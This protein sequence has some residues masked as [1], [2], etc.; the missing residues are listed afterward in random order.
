MR[1]RRKDRDGSDK[2]N[3]AGQQN[4][5]QISLVGVHKIG[6]VLLKKIH[7]VDSTIIPL[8]MLEVCFSLCRVYGGLFLTAEMIDCLLAGD[9]ERAAWFAG[10]LLLLNVF[11]GVAGEVV[12]RKFRGMKN[13]IWLI[14]YVWLREK[15]FSLDYETMENP[16]VAEKILYSERTSD[17]YGGLGIMLYQYCEILRSALNVLLSSAMVLSLCLKEPAQAK[18]ILGML[19]APLSSMLLFALVLTGMMICAFRVFQRFA[20]KQM[21]IFGAH[22]GVENRLM[23]LLNQIYGNVK[24]AKIIRIYGMEEMIMENTRTDQDKSKVYFEQMC[25]VERQEGDAN[26][27]VNSFFTVASYLLVAV[28]TVTG[29]ITVGAFTRYA[30]ALNQFGN[31]CF[32]M[33][34]S[35]GELRKIATYMKEFLDFLNT[36]SMHEKGSIPVE[37]REDGEYELA[38]ENVSFHYPGNEEL[39]LKDVNCRLRIRGKLAVVGRNGAG[40]TTFIKLLCRLYEPTKGRITLNGVDIR[41]YDEEEYRRLFGVV[42]QDFKLFAFPVWENITAGSERQKERIEEALRQADAKEMVEKMPQGIDTYLYKNLEDGVEVSGGEAQKLALARALYKDA[43]VVI[44]DEPTAALDP[45]AEAE[46]YAHFNKMVE[47][48][49]SI[50]ISH[51]MSSCR[52]CDDIIVFENGRIVERGSHEELFAAGGSYARMWNAQAKYYEG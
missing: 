21:E 20:K 35:N 4:E 11:F 31:A 23:Y 13:K 49:T 30:G 38:F 7:S 48:R 34:S 12:R 18:G 40:K 9:F 28:K 42:F 51:R 39:A 37:K 15:A 36:E 50:Y 52:F 14:F 46:V 47:G 25:D 1:K 41:K 45:K 6:F 44:L 43:P 8:H 17:M 22:T 26:K 24:A 19:S 5:P 32:T 29:A 27:L 3:V 16:Q 33:I 10:A 2:K